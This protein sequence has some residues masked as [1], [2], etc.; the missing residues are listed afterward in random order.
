MIGCTYTFGRPFG[1]VAEVAESSGSSRKGEV[2][3]GT[4]ATKGLVTVERIRHRE[5]KEV[6]EVK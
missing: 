2:T 1:V 5:K 3:C 6:K 4:S